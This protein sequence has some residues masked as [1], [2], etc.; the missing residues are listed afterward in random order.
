MPFH[1]MHGN[2]TRTTFTL[3]A[4]RMWCPR[5]RRLDAGLKVLMMQDVDDQ[6]LPACRPALQL[7]TCHTEPTNYYPSSMLEV[8]ARTSGR[9][10]SDVV[11]RGGR[12][13]P[14]TRG[15]TGFCLVL[16]ALPPAIPLLPVLL[17]GNSP[18]Q[19]YVKSTLSETFRE[20]P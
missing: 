17:K 10:H 12:G 4:I 20:H 1:L 5:Q 13:A 14:R 7:L 8:V 11:C 6:S 18:M 19:P 15:S 16:T 3:A 2:S 9:Y